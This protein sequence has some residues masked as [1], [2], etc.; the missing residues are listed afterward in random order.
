MGLASTRAG[1]IRGMEVVVELATMVTAEG[2]KHWRAEVTRDGSLYD[3]SE[4]TVHIAEAIKA[5]RDLKESV[6]SDWAYRD[7]RREAAQLFRTV[8]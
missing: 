3:A 1:K 5:Q 8:A 4:W 6:L 2:L 7:A